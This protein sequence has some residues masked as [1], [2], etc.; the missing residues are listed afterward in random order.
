MDTSGYSIEVGT[1]NSYIDKTNEWTASLANECGLP[2]L[3]T[4]EALKSEDGFLKEGYDSGDGFHLNTEAYR[5]ML[6]YIKTH[7]YGGA[8]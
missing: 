2:Y 3:N 5:Q 7:A 8:E 4:A 6:E 1:L